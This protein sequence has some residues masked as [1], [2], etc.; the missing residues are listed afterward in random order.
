[1]KLYHVGPPKTNRSWWRVLTKH[2]MLEN[3]MANHFSIHAKNS[4]KRQKD[5]TLKGGLPRSV[6]GQYAAREEWKS[7][8]RRNEETEP[9]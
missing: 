3:G 5:M 9:K 6:G 4:M 8:S 2:G 1:M 7:N